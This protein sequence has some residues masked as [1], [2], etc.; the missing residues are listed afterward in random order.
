LIR[1]S[2]HL[3][4]RFFVIL[5]F[6]EIARVRDPEVSVKPVASKEL[7]PFD[8]VSATCTVSAFDETVTVSGSEVPAAVKVSAT[9]VAGAAG[10]PTTAGGADG[11]VG[12]AGG[13]S[14]VV[15]QVA[16]AQGGR[17]RTPPVDRD[18]EPFRRQSPATAGSA[19]DHSAGSDSPRAS[20]ERPPSL[21]R[22]H[23]TDVNVGDLDALRQL[24]RRTG[25]GKG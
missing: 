11:C 12:S 4:L 2:S 3:A 22:G 8:H 5:S 16:L 20:L 6:S 23:P 18:V 1:T 13:G 24:G 14:I 15:V 25:E 17:D 10:G 21:C 9:V 7:L 19:K